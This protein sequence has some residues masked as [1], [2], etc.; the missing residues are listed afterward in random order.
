MLGVDAQANTVTWRLL[1]L[2][3]RVLA[4]VGLD[5]VAR[6]STI[7]RHRPFLEVLPDGIGVRND[8]GD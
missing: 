3:L 6:P 2:A 7:A 4:L 5:L 1:R 8:I